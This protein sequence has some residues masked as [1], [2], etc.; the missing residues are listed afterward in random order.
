MK[1]DSH[2]MVTDERPESGWGQRVYLRD[3]CLCGKQVHDLDAELAC[4]MLTDVRKSRKVSG[5][6]AGHEIGISGNAVYRWGRGDVRPVGLSRRALEEWLC[7]GAIQFVRA[8]DRVETPLGPGT[9]LADSLDASGNPIRRTPVMLDGHG[10]KF[11]D[12]P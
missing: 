10:A 12:Q 5:E 4:G 2:W 11:K 1:L 7:K 9:A 3:V 8:G 6:V